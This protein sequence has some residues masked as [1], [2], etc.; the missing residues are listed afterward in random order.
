[1]PPSENRSDVH[2]LLALLLTAV[3][4]QRGSRSI[5]FALT[6]IFQLAFHRCLEGRLFPQWFNDCFHF[7]PDQHIVVEFG[8]YLAQAHF[9]HLFRWKTDSLEALITRQKFFE[10]AREIGVNPKRIRYWGMIIDN[11]MTLLEK[12]TSA[13]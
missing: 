11:E 1:M 13:R 3:A 5:R 12:I 8:G 2:L 4:Q 7:D 10:I 6:P 9:S